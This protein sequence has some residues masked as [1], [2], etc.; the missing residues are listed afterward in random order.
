MSYRLYAG[1]NHAWLVVPDCMLPPHYATDLHGPLSF[2]GE[3]DPMV[4]SPTESAE[5]QAGLEAQLFAEISE[6]VAQLLA[7]SI[8]PAIHTHSGSDEKPLSSFAT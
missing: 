2:L 3:A 5:I 8:P 7:A 6:Q 4:L 1:E